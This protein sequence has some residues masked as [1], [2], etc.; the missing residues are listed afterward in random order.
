M[1]EL[2]FKS[3]GETP[4]VSQNAQNRVEPNPIGLVTPMRLSKTQ[5]DI[6]E[7]QYDVQDQI[8]DNLRNLILTNHGERLGM[9]DFG[10]NIR[11]LIFSL[12]GGNFEKEVMTR[13]KS[14]AIKFLP[15]IELETFEISYDN[16]DTKKGF[17]TIGMLISY[18]VPAIGVSG[19]RMQVVITAGG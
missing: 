8:D 19:K 14:A 10:A 15:F 7:M 11:P 16:R 17:A 2:S 6:F 5:K 1:P 3:V 9:Q 12:T 13:I 18:G 4:S